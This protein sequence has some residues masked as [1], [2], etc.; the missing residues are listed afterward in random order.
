MG[1]VLVGSL[2]SCSHFVCIQGSIGLPGI[3]GQKVSIINQSQLLRDEQIIPQL[4][5]SARASRDQKESQE[6]QERGVPL[7]DLGREANR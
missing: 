5:F 1:T 7:G 2:T 3:L 6:S 4:C